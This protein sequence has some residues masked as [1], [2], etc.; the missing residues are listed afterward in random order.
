MTLC[1]IIPAAGHGS[2]LG[3]DKPKLLVPVTNDLTIWDILKRRLLE[4]CDHIVVVMSP[5]GEPFLQELLRSDPERKR[6]SVVLQDKPIGMGDAVMRG[7]NVWRNYDNICIIWGDQVHVSHDTIARS[8]ETQKAM[9]CP[10]FTLPLTRLASPYVEYRVDAKN[11]LTHILESREGDLCAP[12]GFGDVGTF[13]LSTAGL[14]CVW[15][16]YEATA[17]RGT[18]TGEINFLPFLIYLTQ[19]SWNCAQVIVADADEAKGI[20]TP[21][22]LD[23]FR[24][25]YKL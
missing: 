14:E 5:W 11:R 22:D 24:R 1:G 18:R 7:C 13:L 8:I 20:N 15:K 9:P 17:P 6:V 25:L 12:G 2:R 21:Q 4:F 19:K 10:C 23:Y 16:E 3:F